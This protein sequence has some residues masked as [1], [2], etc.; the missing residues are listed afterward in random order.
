[1][2]DNFL[3]SKLL[4]RYSLGLISRKELESH[5][6]KFVLENRREFRPHKWTDDEYTDFVCAFYPRIRRAIDNYRETG[7]SF[8]AYICT[9]VRWGIKETRVRETD[10]HVVEY[11]CWEAKAL[12]EAAVHEEEDM[13]NEPEPVFREVSNPR[14]VLVLLLKSYHYMSPDFLER[15]SPALNIDKE[16]LKDMIDGVRELRLEREETIKALQERI[17]TQFYRCVVFE[18]KLKSAIPNSERHKKLCARLT[19]GRA[20]LK[21]MRNRLA[22]MKTGA[23]NRQVAQ[24]LESSKGTIDA[25]LSSVKEKLGEWPD[26]DLYGEDDEHEGGFNDASTC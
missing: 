8:D 2:R 6:F 13:Y 21:S 23:S 16:K 14:Q 12:D 7:A 25:H 1:M 26:E 11:A 19:R 22:G 15:I 20:R 10:R 24:I 17:Y 3:L 4:T 18:K 5:I 9:L